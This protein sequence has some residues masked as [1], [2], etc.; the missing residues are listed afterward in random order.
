MAKRLLT[1]YVAGNQEPGKED[2]TKAPTFLKWLVYWTDRGIM[3]EMPHCDP[4]KKMML[5]DYEDMEL[6]VVQV[7]LFVLVEVEQ[8][9]MVH[10][11]M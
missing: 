1:T 3:L 4:M 9:V 7:I 8:M 2:N 6:V 10:K 11:V 5:D